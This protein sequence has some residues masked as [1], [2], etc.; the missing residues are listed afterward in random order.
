MSTAR[1][2]AP[3]ALLPGGWARKVLFEV[4]A[5]GEILSATANA[6]PAGAEILAGPVIPGMPNLHSHAFQRAMAGLTEKG[7]PQGDSFWS[8][9]KLMYGFL[10]DLTPD[11][12]EVIA[13]QLYIEMLCAGYTAVAE[14]HYLH[15]DAQGRPYANR[16]E[17]GERIAAAAAATGISLTLMPVFYAHGGFGGAPP[18]PGQRRFVN[19]REGY[20][21]IVESLAACVRKQPAQRIGVAPHS[22]RAATPEE[23]HAAV[24]CIDAIDRQAPIHIHAAEQQQEV[25]DCLQWGGVRPVA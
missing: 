17:V 15:H 9:R 16:G 3:S 24:A 25:D 13:T 12:V 7:G 21:R 18:T 19:D 6:D 22:L 2:L 5:Q 11:D 20:A 4:S 1:Y 23:L 14:F 8:W 10:E